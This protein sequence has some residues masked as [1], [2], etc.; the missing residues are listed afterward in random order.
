MKYKFFREKNALGLEK[1]FKVVSPDEETL[2]K[3]IRAKFLQKADMIDVIFNEKAREK[4]LQSKNKVVPEGLPEFE[5][6][7]R[8]APRVFADFSQL[9]IDLLRCHGAYQNIFNITPA[10]PTLENFDDRK[11]S[12]EIHELVKKIQKENDFFELL[13]DLCSKLKLI[14]KYFEITN[15]EIEELRVQTEQLEGSFFNG[16]IVYGI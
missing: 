1:E 16:K 5:I 10:K 2:E 6:Q 14:T 12:E 4:Y 8:I 9:S 13:S 11:L 15:E 3:E 7:R